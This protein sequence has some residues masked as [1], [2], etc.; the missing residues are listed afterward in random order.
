MTYGLVGTL[1]AAPG[2]R[3]ALVT[4]MLRA[5]EALRTNPEC[6]VYLVATSDAP[7]DV[8]ITEV[9]S[10]EA[11]HDASLTDPAVQA[12]IAEVR[13]LLAG[14]GSRTV[15]DVHGGIGAPRAT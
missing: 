4:H 13:P 11:A 8:L 2:H 3:A 1:V 15:L 5:A 12:L 10:S 9:W 7:D 14:M 6:H